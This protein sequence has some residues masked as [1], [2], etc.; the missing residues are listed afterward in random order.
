MNAAPRVDLSLASMPQ[1]QTYEDRYQGFLDIF[2]RIAGMPGGVIVTVSHAPYS[3][4]PLLHHLNV[5]TTEPRM[6]FQHDMLVSGVY[7]R[8]DA[9][10]DRTALEVLC[11]FR[12]ETAD[13]LWK[14]D[15]QWRTPPGRVREYSEGG[16]FI[17]TSNGSFHRREVIEYMDK[18]REYTPTKRKVVIVPCAA[19]KPYPSPLHRRI[20]SKLPDDWYMMTATG[21]VGVVPEDLWPIMPHYDSGIPNEWR[22]YQALQNYFMNNHHD[23]IVVYCDYYSIAI[24]EALRSIGQDNRATYILP[25]KFYADYVNLMDERHLAQLLHKIALLDNRA[26]TEALESKASAR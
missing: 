4:L 6:F 2:K 17:V 3:W 7:L 20:Q 10:L 22:L 19:D 14:I 15:M 16:E 9:P 5:I 21:V 24:R 11:G 8:A 13:A 1:G 12:P 25:V 18:L 23:Q 26:T